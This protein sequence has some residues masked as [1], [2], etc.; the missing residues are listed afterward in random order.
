MSYRVYISH[1]SRDKE[2]ARDLTR[3]LKEAGVTVSAAESTEPGEDISLHIKNSLRSADEVVV[4]L[5]ENSLKSSWLQYEIGAAD[6]L[7]KRVTPILVNEGAELLPQISGRQLIRYADLPRY[8]SSLKR[9]A[10]AA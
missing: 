3:R 5:T 6:S 9:R 1:T 7:D 4:L 10:K 8:I 2:L